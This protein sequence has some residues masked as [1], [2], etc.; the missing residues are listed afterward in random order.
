[1]GVIHLLIVSGYHRNILFYILSKIFKRIIRRKGY[2]FLVYLFLFFYLY[3]LNFH[4]ASVKGIV[5]LS[6]SL[7]NVRFWDYKLIAKQKW[8]LSIL[9]ILLFFPYIF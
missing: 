6:L 9:L 7:F 1:M 2:Y 3:L 8:N 5:F 4:L